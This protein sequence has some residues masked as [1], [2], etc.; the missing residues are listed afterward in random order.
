M[1]G[2]ENKEVVDQKL[3]INDINKML[4]SLW[5]EDSK[6]FQL[7]SDYEDLIHVD[8]SELNYKEGPEE[9]EDEETQKEPWN[10][11]EKRIENGP[12]TLE[13]KS[14]AYKE[15]VN[16]LQQLEQQGV[17]NLKIMDL[18]PDFTWGVM[19]PVESQKVIDITQAIADYFHGDSLTYVLKFEWNQIN[20]RALQNLAKTQV[21]EIKLNSFT[22]E[23]WDAQ[24]AAIMKDFPG[25]ITN[26]FT[27]HVIKNP[28]E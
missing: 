25:K 28:S 21:K 9:P 15:T 2:L 27:Q 4:E 10:E 5:K 18:F 12:D 16:K 20:M 6:R 13:G 23:E 26:I 3:D 11:D 1:T 14:E 24:L 19:D 17:K 8:E 22:A 7:K